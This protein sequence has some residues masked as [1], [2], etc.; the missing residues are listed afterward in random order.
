MVSWRVIT[1]RVR[2]NKLNKILFG[3][4]GLIYTLTLNPSIDYYMSIDNIAV[5]EVNRSSGESLAFGGKGINVSRMLKNLGGQSRAVAVVGSGCMSEVLVN[6]LKAEGLNIVPVYANGDTRI[7]VKLK[8]SVS[9]ITELNGIGVNATEATVREVFSTLSEAEKGDIAVLSGSICQGVPKNIYQDLVGE[10][11]SRGV[12]TVVDA[13]GDALANAVKAK[14]YLIKP[15]RSELERLTGKKFETVDDVISTAQG[16]VQAGVKNVLVSMGADGAVL[17]NYEIYFMPVHRV[18]GGN[19]VGAGDSLLAGFVYG[20]EKGMSPYS[21]L[22][23]AV[24]CARSRVGGEPLP[25]VENDLFG[26]IYK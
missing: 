24:A 19:T 14:P 5:G 4:I 16:I 18:D 10:L 15:N 6:E 22:S 13:D 1:K 2:K 20:M 9:D 21:C 17:V 12:L 25:S 23:F 7:N 3:V 8:S 26:E 11:N